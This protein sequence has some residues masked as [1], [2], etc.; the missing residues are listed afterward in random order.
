MRWDLTRKARGLNRERNGR[1][2]GIL[3]TTKKPFIKI[4]VVID[5]GN[6]VH[7]KLRKNE[8]TI[9]FDVLKY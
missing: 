1:F 3:L 2:G 4:I 9:I 5:P 8:I 6:K 7:S